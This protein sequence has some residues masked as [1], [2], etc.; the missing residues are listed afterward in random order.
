LH[1]LLRSELG[2]D[3]Q[4]FAA[5]LDEAR[6]GPEAGAAAAA[7]NARRELRALLRVV[8]NRLGRTARLRGL[9]A[10]RSLRA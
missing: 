9:V 4:R 10:M 2:A 8:R 5:A 6:F 3:G 7:G 1:E